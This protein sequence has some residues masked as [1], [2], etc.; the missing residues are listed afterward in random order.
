MIFVTL[1]SLQGLPEARSLK[2]QRVNAASKGP[3]GTIEFGHFLLG[4]LENQN[5]A[6]PKMKHWR[7]C[8]GQHIYKV[9]NDIS[10]CPFK[11][12]VH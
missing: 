6:F 8:V 2:E 11:N 10:K 9:R 4:I 3:V 5:D 12:N 7:S 1:W